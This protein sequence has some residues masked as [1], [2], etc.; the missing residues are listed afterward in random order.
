MTTHLQLNLKR[1][2]HQEQPVHM[3][4][5]IELKWEL[6]VSV[7]IAPLFFNS[8]IN[9]TSRSQISTEK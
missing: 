8:Y 2:I 6:K 7:A 1:K 3:L 5:F 4:I 9:R